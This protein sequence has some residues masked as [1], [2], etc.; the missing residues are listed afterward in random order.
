MQKLIVLGILIIIIGCVVLFCGII[1]SLYKQGESSTGNAIKTGG[2][3]LIGPIP[4][5]FGNDKTLILISA[6]GAILS[7]AAYY[8]WR[9]R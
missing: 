8:L 2:I 4:I 1:N 5:L 6:C 7:I 3:I 9:S